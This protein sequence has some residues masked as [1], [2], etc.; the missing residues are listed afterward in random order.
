MA[1]TLW[2]ILDVIV[3]VM[4]IVMFPAYPNM[5]GNGFGGAFGDY[6]SNETR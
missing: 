2:Y 1:I 6:V 4:M 3:A 5:N